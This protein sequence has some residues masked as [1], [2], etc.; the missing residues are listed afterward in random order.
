MSGGPAGA[1]V[2]EVIDDRR[3]ELPATRAY[4]RQEWSFVRRVGVVLAFVALCL[5]CGR[6]YEPLRATG[7]LL[8][9]IVTLVVLAVVIGS[10]IERRRAPGPDGDPEQVDGRWI[11]PF[12]AS[13][14]AG[15]SDFPLPVSTEPAFARRSILTAAVLVVV[16]YAVGAGTGNGITAAYVMLVLSIF[17]FLVVWSFRE[18]GQGATV[19]VRLGD[20]GVTITDRHRPTFAIELPWS[21]VARVQ[22]IRVDRTT[23]LVVITATAGGTAVISYGSGNRAFVPTLER[24]GARVAS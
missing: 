4:R 18:V 2:V 20:T 8:A 24:L 15:S 12:D 11:G 1:L 19:G 13:G 9:G 5:L 21:G 7:V 16:G 14:I 23:R 22:E 3:H 6:T 10:T 17:G